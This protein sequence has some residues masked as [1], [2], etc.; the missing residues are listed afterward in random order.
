MSTSAVDSSLYASPASTNQSSAGGTYGLSETDF[1]DLLVDQLKNQDP[2]N[3]QD[4]SQFAAQLAEFTTVQ[5]LQTLNQNV[6]SQMQSME[7][8]EA[9]SLI[10]RTVTVGTGN[11][12]TVSGTVQSVSYTAGSDP[13][14]VINGQGYDFNA[15]QEIQ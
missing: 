11:N 15:I 13:Q 14:V 4:P 2:D 12:Q 6:V 9:A 3:P 8:G 7:L 10:G 1:L 5:E